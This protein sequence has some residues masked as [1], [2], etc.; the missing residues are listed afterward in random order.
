MIEFDSETNNL[1]VLIKDKDGNVKLSLDYDAISS[2][3]AVFD[4]SKEFRPR[5]IA[6]SV[7]LA[8]IGVLWLMRRLLSKRSSKDPVAQ[9][10]KTKT[11]RT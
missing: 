10:K 11:K 7:A 8:L 2:S 1:T 3:C 4:E 5:T 6:I 9:K